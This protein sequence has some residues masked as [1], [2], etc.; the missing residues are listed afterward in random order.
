MGN[1]AERTTASQ[2]AQAPQQPA[3]GP[4]APGDGADRV[5]A[6]S[7]LAKREGAAEQS[8][9][10]AD[11]DTPSSHVPDDAAN[12]PVVAKADSGSSSSSS[13]GSSD[14]NRGS[15]GTS[16]DEE[17]AADAEGGSGQV[18]L[19]EAERAFWGGGSAATHLA[20]GAARRDQGDATAGWT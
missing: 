16:D 5:A 8:H 18:G 15:S 9:S 4:S 19:T 3:P 7:G 1:G 12:E 17:M 2:L 11:S 20:G 13:S 14:E 6:L 10:G